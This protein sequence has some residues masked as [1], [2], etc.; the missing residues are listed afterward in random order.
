MNVLPASAPAQGVAAENPLP[1]HA[2]P[3]QQGDGPGGILR[4]GGYLVG[5]QD[6]K[7][8]IQQGGVGQPSS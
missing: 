6:G 4:L 3:L 2:Q 8:V 5:I 7:G 1:N